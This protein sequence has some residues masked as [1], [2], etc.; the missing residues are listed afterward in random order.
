MAHLVEEYAKNLGV[1]ISNPIVKD[2]FFP[3]GFD[4]YIT[5][6]QEKTTESKLYPYFGMVLNLLKPFLERAKIKVI[7]IGGKEAIEGV[8]AALNLSFKQESFVLSK[9]LVHVGPDGVLNHLASSKNIP[10]VTLFGNIFSESNKPIFSKSGSVN[11]NLTPEWEKKPCLAPIDPQRQI[12]NIKPEIIAQSILDFLDIE[13]EDIS[14]ETKYIGDSFLS[15]SVEVVPTTYHPLQIPPNQILMVRADY[16]Y[17]EDAFMQYCTK[18]RVNICA[19][20]LI[21]P[22]GLQKIAANVGNFHIFVDSDWDDIPES[23]FETLKNLNINVR[24][25]VLD[26]DDLPVIR[27]KYFDIPVLQYYED[28]KA[29][30]DLTEQTKFLS[31]LRLIQDGKEYLSYAHWKKGLD[32]NNKVLDT[33]EYWRQ[34]NHFYIYEPE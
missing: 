25:L 5:I 24:L 15:P 18:H 28:K 12:N 31:S 32:R 6:A 22:H 16:G 26:P 17:N 1:K 7:Q 29:P 21:Q 20:Q 11:V 27:N 23:Y 4:K 8:D 9:S 14:F 13:K 30:C 10:T 19:K 34:L 2:H 33:A 3:I